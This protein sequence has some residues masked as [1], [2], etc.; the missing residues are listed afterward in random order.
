MKFLNATIL[1]AVL[2][3]AHATSGMAQQLISTP[4]SELRGYLTGGAGTTTT[5]SPTTLTLSAEIAENMTSD[6]QAY[7]SFW[8]YDNLLSSAARNQLAQV[9]SYLTSVTGVPWQFEGRDRG[10]SFTVGGKFLI[11]TGTGVRPYVGG[12]VGA[13]NLRPTITE[14]TRGIV[15]GPFLTTYGVSD[16]VI[17]ITQTNTTLPMGELA[18]GVGIVIRHAYIDVGYRYRKAFHTAGVSFDTSQANVAVGVKF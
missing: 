3:V 1:A 7:M 12:G 17:D 14:R 13:L 4:S 6:L 2:V 9:G 16:G 11:P 5:G 8:Y 10:R 18:G 15:T